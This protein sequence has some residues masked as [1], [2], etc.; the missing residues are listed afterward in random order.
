VPVVEEEGGLGEEGGP[1]EEGGS[2]EVGSYKG[3]TNV[4]YLCF[5]QVNSTTH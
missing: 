2:D 3:S 1:G 4:M 5:M